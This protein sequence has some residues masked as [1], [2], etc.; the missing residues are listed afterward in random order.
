[1]WNMVNTP[2]ITIITTIIIERNTP[3]DFTI[4]CVFMCFEVSL[5]WEKK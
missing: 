1:M 2:A 4:G 3:Y 5:T